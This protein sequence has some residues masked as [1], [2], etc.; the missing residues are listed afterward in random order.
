[1]TPALIEQRK[2]ESSERIILLRC[3][4]KLRKGKSVVAP[5][6]DGA[7]VWDAENDGEFAVTIVKINKENGTKCGKV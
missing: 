5:N 3:A 4:A 1:L 7:L 6:E 2:V